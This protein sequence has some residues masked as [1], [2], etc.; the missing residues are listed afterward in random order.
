MSQCGFSAYVGAP[1]APS[2]AVTGWTSVNADGR[3]DSVPNAS[4]TT[5]QVFNAYMNQLPPGTPG[6]GFALQSLTNGRY[7]VA[8]TQSIAGTDRTVFQPSRRA[9][10]AARSGSSRTRLPET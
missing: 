10:S 1:V 2:G 7:V 3:L 8:A 6:Q 5:S 4:S 9:S